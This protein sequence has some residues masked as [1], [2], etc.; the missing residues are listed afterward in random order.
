M[1]RLLHSSLFRKGP[2]EQ[3]SR[4]R[5]PSAKMVA[6]SGSVFAPEHKN[7]NSKPATNVGAMTANSPVKLEAGH[8]FMG[9]QSKI[10]LMVT[11]AF[12]TAISMSSFAFR[13]YTL[14]KGAMKMADLERSLNHLK[15]AMNVDTIRQYQIKKSWG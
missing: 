1:K 5:T 14:D 13:F 11:L 9:R 8:L 4:R 3:H 10:F 12:M 15:A 2:S 7:R 6:N